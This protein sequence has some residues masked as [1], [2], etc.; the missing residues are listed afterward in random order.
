MILPEIDPVA[1]QIGPLAIRW[2]SLTWLAAFA[3]IYSLAKYRLKAFSKEQLSDLMFYGLLGAMLGG[4]AG[5]CFFYG[6]D[7]L[8]EDPLSLLRVWE[9]GLSF[10]GGL[11]GVLIAVYFLARSWGVRYFEILDFIAPSVPLGLGLVRIGNFLNSELLGRPTDQSWGVVFPS[12]PSGLLRHPSQ[13]YQAFSEGI[14]LL[15]FL[16]WIARKP[17]PSM[18]VSSYFL[19]G[20]GTVRTVTE[21]FREPDAHI[22]FDAFNFL[23]RGQLLSIPMVLTGLL[24]LFFSY[25]LTRKNETIP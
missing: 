13:L 19:I 9:G 16:L 23:T 10:H 7:Q 20:Y 18:A 22:G 1:L 4:R 5:Y 6:I 17:K 3:G 11:L 8:I 24:L 12:D 21:F 15:I 2:Y 14:L 25:K